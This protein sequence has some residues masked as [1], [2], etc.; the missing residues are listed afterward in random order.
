MPIDRA[1]LHNTLSIQSAPHESERMNRYLRRFARRHNIA[2]V[3]DNGNIYMKK[4][5]AEIY[6]CVV[7]HTDT[8]HPIISDFVVNYRDGVYSGKNRSTGVQYGVGGDDK[9][10]IAVALHFLLHADAIKVAFFRDE[11]IGC[12]GSSQARMDFF[13]DCSFVAQAD[14]RGNRDI[15]H[16]IGNVSLYNE[17][18]SDAISPY[19]ALFG[20][21][22]TSGALTDVY[23]LK[24]KGLDIACFN[25]SAGYYDPHTDK[26]TVVASDVDNVV[27]FLEALIDNL[28]DRRWES[29]MSLQ[30]TY[31][32]A[33][34]RYI[35][36]IYGVGVEEEEDDIDDNDIE[37]YIRRWVRIDK[38]AIDVCPQCG[39]TQTD[40]DDSVGFYWCHSCGDYV[41]Q[42]V[43]YAQHES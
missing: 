40:Y 4:G 18:F 36:N 33:Y 42:E 21:S 30:S 34:P 35:S 16:A 6:P 43:D 1:L 2:F 11:E 9:V 13:H 14:R 39:G 10:G 8:V 32:L 37:D 19:L 23:K 26:E 28:G 41:F 29:E 24:T 22:E 27:H 15:V 20:F 12:V 5:E 7:A 31:S 38:S 25:L 17:E 3:E